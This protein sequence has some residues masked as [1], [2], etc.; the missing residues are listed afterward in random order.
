MS[1]CVCIHGHL[2]FEIQFL[3]GSEVS[4]MIELLFFLLKIYFYL[5]AWLYECICTI[6]AGFLGGQKRAVYR[7][8]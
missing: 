7:L 1:V 6:S 5:C 3:T 8:D 4:Y 2:V